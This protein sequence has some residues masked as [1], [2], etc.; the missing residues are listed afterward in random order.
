MG[1]LTITGPNST[2]VQ[3]SGALPI[4]V[5]H[6]TDGAAVVNVQNNAHLVTG[7]GGF[8]VNATGQVN[9]ESGAILDAYGPITLNGGAFNFLGGTLHVETFD[10]NLVND[11][12]ALAP[13]HSVGTTDVSGNYTQ[14]PAA[15]L[16]IEIAGVFPGDWDVLTVEGNA[17]LD[18]TI[19]VALLDDFE[20]VLGNSFTIVTTNVGNVGGQFET[21]LLPTFN[22]LTFEVIY[23]PKSVVLQ[24]IESNVLLGD[25]NFD[26]TVDAAD[27]VVWR[28]G[29]DTTYMQDDYDVWRTHFGQTAGS[30]SGSFDNNFVP[31]PTSAAMLIV[32]FLI[33]SFASGRRCRKLIRS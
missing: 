6:A 29:L 24:V 22:G 13:G 31:E 14:R 20:P 21:E 10:G 3:Q 2:L 1:T 28:K 25:Y 17:S 11:G 26:G 7:T 16:E 15:A 5:G 8:S 27:Y 4:A 9:L 18:G 32:G 23:N 19:E 33:C 30:G 12:G